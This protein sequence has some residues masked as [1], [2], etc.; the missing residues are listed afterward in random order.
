M[1]LVPLSALGTFV[2]LVSSSAL[3]DVSSSDQDVDIVRGLLAKKQQFTACHVPSNIAEALE[4]LFANHELD[5]SLVN[6]ELDAIPD[7]P[8][9]KGGQ[10]LWNRWGQRVRDARTKTLV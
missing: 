9:W 10:E 1:R 3:F 4:T 7:Y 5:P 2:A 6:L 8:L